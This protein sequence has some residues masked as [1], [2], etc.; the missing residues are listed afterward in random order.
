MTKVANQHNGVVRDVLFVDV[1][2]V[3]AVIL[4]ILPQ[5]L[6][7]RECLFILIVHWLRSG[8]DK[9]AVDAVCK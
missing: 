7:R 1:D 2:D 5:T 3:L 6:L 4:T 9:P 8:I